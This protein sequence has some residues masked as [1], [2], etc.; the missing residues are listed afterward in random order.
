[1]ETENFYQDFHRKRKFQKRIINDK[2][3]TYRNI[4]KLLN[5]YAEGRDIIDIGCGVGTLDFYLASK[6]KKV[7]GLDISRNA[8]EIAKI[9]AK[10][11]GVSESI[12]FKVSKFPSKVSRIKKKFD[13]ALCIAVLEHI[14]NDKK[15][16][17]EI[18]KVLKNKGSALFSV[19]SENSPLYRF[20]LAKSYEE[21]VG[22]LRR[23]NEKKFTLLLESSGYKILEIKKEEGFLRE[24]LFIFKPAELLI[25]IAN[26]FEI[27]S[28]LLTYLDNLLKV[29]GEAQ[30][31]VIAVK[32]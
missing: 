31:N 25:K 10:K 32:K 3:F 19:P 28:D 21:R 24:A 2:N 14:K 23:Y 5:K 6:G 20:G 1:M 7:L 22:H 4:V 30:I 11:L 16:L 15:A 18:Y 8:I 29:F 12:T 17:Q 27:F 26:R 13:F 9:N